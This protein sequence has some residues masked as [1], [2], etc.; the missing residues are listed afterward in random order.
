MMWLHSKLLHSDT[1]RIGIIGGSITQGTLA[2]PSENAYGAR[3]CRFLENNFP[4]KK[5]A[6]INAGIGATNSRFACSRVRNDLLSQNPDL[7]IIEYA[8][9]DGIS[10]S[11]AYEG[12]IRT[13]LK[14]T[15]GPT[16]LFFTLNQTGESTNQK[17]QSRIGTHYDLPMISYRDAVWPL[18]V[19]NELS[20]NSISA[21][22]VHPNNNGHLV[23]AHLL[24]SFLKLSLSGL[25]NLSNTK[26]PIPEPLITDFFES[27]GIL[28][29]II[30]E[31]EKFN[32]NNWNQI[33]KEYGRVEY[34]S[35]NPSDTISF[36]TSFREVTIGY[37]YSKEG[38]ANL[39]IILDGEPVATLNNYFANDW[40]GGYMRLFTIYKDT[41]PAKH[42]LML[43]N[44]EGNLFTIEYFL[45]VD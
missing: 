13:C 42:N 20:W 41:I 40:G 36:E 8:V 21:D 9:N 17:I 44:T 3:L 1:I 23:C 30:L 31:S 15:D 14:N 2:S 19:A 18:L 29:T 28:D 25:Q 7:T 5:F 16:I 26:P 35:A 33:V 24:Y 27:A 34:S 38:D 4:E 32:F 12:L 37:R 6:L 45:Y 11:A 22:V 39:Q 43:I 10:D